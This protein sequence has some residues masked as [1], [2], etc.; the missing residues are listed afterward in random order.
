VEGLP[1]VHRLIAE[2]APC[3][4][5]L[6]EGFKH[7]DLPKLEVWRAALGQR[8]A[9]PDDPF[10]T[11]VLTDTPDALPQPTALPVLRLGDAAGLAAHLRADG[12]RYDYLP[13]NHGR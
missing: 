1:S 13:E 7:A 6:V 11:T 2:M 12:L 9:Y 5:L 10:V 3:D 4:W 8:P